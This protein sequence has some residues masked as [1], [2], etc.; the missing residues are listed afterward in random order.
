MRPVTQSPLCE[1]AKAAS[2]RF[3]LTRCTRSFG[4]GYPSSWSYKSCVAYC[5]DL[6][7]GCQK[8]LEGLFARKNGQV[9]AGEDLL[10]VFGKGHLNDGVVFVLTE[11][12]ADGG[13]FVRQADVTVV[14][15]HVHLHLADVLV[16]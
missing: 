8:A 5:G 1:A 3:R 2:L 14:V 11:D 6:S 10:I 4:A 12:D 9:A 15:V 16:A 7:R 13:V